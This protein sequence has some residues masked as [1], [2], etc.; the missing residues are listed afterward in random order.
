MTV[1]WAEVVAVE[2]ERRLCI[3]WVLVGWD[4][5]ESAVRH[6]FE[7]RKQEFGLVF[8]KSGLSKSYLSEDV[9]RLDGRHSSK[10]GIGS[11]GYGEGEMTGGAQRIFRAVDYSV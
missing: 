1:A 6:R 10:K 8:G 7:E 4:G 11:R 9:G 2:V 5:G 3:L